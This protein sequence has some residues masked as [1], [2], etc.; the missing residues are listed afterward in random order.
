MALGNIRQV[1]AYGICVS[2]NHP[3]DM[4]PTLQ[5]D[6]PEQINAV[7]GF[8]GPP[9]RKYDPYASTYNPGWRDHPNFSY[10]A[11]PQ[12]FQQYQSRPP[13]PAPQ[14]SSSSGMSLEDIVKSLAINTKQFQEETKL[15]IQNLENQVSRLASS[16][17]KLESQGKLPSQTVTNSK[18]S[19]NAVT[20]RSGK[21]L[22]GPNKKARNN[23]LEEQIEREVVTP[24]I[25]H[26]QS[27]GPSVEPRKPLVITPP[28][29]SRLARSKKEEEEKG[30]LETFRKVE[31]NIPLL[32]AIKQLPRYANFS[33]SC[34]LTRKS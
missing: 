32:D 18:Q 25:Q 20:L 22:Q 26:D 16:M 23:D 17:S 27:G 12:Y 31:V 19:V 1:K 28:F 30:I 15:S 2:L 6:T 10:G 33:R 3:T 8:P 9:Q 11:R 34:A 24:H 5:E 7:G 29:P 13:V 21:E 14:A 4:Y